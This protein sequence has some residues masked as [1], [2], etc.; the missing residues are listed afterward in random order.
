[1]ANPATQVILLP[2]IVMPAEL[3]YGG[4]L[5]ALGPAVDAKPKDLEIYAGPEPPPGYSLEDEVTGILR[6][7]DAAGFERFHLV[8]YSGGGASSLAFAAKHPQRLLS[9]A[10]LEPAWAGNDGLGPEEEALQ[11]QFDEAMALEPGERMAA[12][13]RL[14]LRP[15]VTPPPPPPGPPPPW[16]ALRPAAI[17]AFLRAL[18][19]YNLDLDRLRAFTPPVYYA[20]GGL[21]NPDYFERQAGR[22]AALFPDFTLEVYEERHH[23]DPPHR[24]EPQRLADALQ[25][26]WTRSRA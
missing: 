10:V 26:L 23:F 21:S 22:L 9:L 8:G 11:A 25:Q 3:A 12:F 5:E 7:A 16:M 24:V 2:G 14:Q 18:R 15:G 6:S 1:M 4:L 19:A 20:L 17:V 13:V